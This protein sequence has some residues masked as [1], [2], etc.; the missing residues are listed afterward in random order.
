M[1]V[2]RP[3][4]VVIFL[5]DLIRLPALLWVLPA[6][7]VMPETAGDIGVPLAVYAAPNA[8][9]PLMA[10]FL[11]LKPAEYRPF[12]PLYLAGKA[13]AVAANLGWFFA[14]VGR[15]RAALPGGVYGVLYTL[16]FLL[17]LAVLDALSVLG[18]SAFM[19][20]QKP[21]PEAEE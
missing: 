1:S 19:L 8:L 9:F 14:S 10:L 4:K 13:A 5:Y 6:L 17:F 16:G 20:P 12:V 11:L 3:L 7:L 2:F 18:M 21:K 15:L